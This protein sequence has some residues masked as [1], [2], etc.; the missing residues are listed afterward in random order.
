[1][2]KSVLWMTCCLISGMSLAQTTRY[3]VIINEFLPDPTPTV[4][5]PNCEFIE[6]KNISDEAIQLEKWRIEN[7]TTSAVINTS[8][9]LQPDS[10]AIICSK[11]QAAAF[12]RPGKTIGIS[13]FP[14]LNNESG[15]IILKD[16]SG[17]TIHAVSYDQSCYKSPTKS[18]GGWSLEMI[19][20]T[21]VCDKNNWQASI[22]DSGGTPGKENSI[23]NIKQPSRNIQATQCTAT[24]PTRLLLKLN[25]GA[26]SLSLSLA[27]KYTLLTS[28]IDI[29]SAKPLAPLFNTVELLLNDGMQE[30]KIYELDVKGLSHCNQA[31]SDNLLIKTGLYSAVKKNDLV[32]NEILFDP[33]TGGSDFIELYNKTSSL[34]NAKEIYLSSRNFNGL[35]NKITQATKDNYTIFPG[36]HVVFTEDTSYLKSKWKT[37]DSLLIENTNMPSMPDD[38]GNVVILDKHGE[39]IDELTYSK[40]MH[41][42]LLRN[43]AGVS[44]ERINP[45]ALS[46]QKE[47]WHSSSS[48]NNYATPT[49]KNSQYIAEA[50]L[51]KNINIFPELISPNNDGIDD[52]LK[53]EY[54]FSNNGHL[55]SIYVYDY[56]GRLITKIADNLLCGTKGMITW[57]GLDKQNRKPNTG[58][59]IIYAESFD[60]NGRRIRT[61]K[62]VGI[63]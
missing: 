3:S 61:K 21:N 24:E 26:D 9:L 6:L 23:V 56:N 53:I 50:D 46:I 49:R 59:Y 62:A 35:I 11:T 30:N 40:E 4:G 60:L 45:N 38:N 57:N 52:I 36:D 20:P 63:Y 58:L 2:N 10:L 14:T 5:L 16:A 42:P 51:E 28:E 15:M 47:N 19:D 55:L 22:N 54:S 33:E 37:G 27:D 12:N 8:Y 48:T 31:S 43:V 18:D 41:F 32:I 13:S 7:G 39:V 44:L 1:M 17:K 34:I 25:Q 29:L